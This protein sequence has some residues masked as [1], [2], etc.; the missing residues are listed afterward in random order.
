MTDFA[1]S[2]RNL[3]TDFLAVVVQ[4]LSQ[5]ELEF[6]LKRVVHHAGRT[7]WQATQEGFLRQLDQP[8]EAAESA[9]RSFKRARLASETDTHEMRM[10][11]EKEVSKSQYFLAAHNLFWPMVVMPWVVR[12][13]H[14]QLKD[15]PVSSAMHRGLGHIKFSAFQTLDDGTVV[16]VRLVTDTWPDVV[17]SALCYDC[18]PLHWRRANEDAAKQ[19]VRECAQDFADA[20]RVLADVVSETVSEA[21]NDPEAHDMGTAKIQPHQELALSKRKSHI[22]QALFYGKVF[23]PDDRWSTARIAEKA[24]GIS[25]DPE[26]FKVPISELRK[27]DL[28]NTKAGR[29]GGCWLTPEGA[30]AA[31]QLLTP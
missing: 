2:F 20:C 1:A 27:D 4:H 3:A 31:Q 17:V 29:D 5:D 12:H 28:I 10:I 23:R 19:E 25:A 24:E 13:H 21:R 14:D 11:A 16:E 15:S 22:L 6:N 9:W 18:D 7:A 8:V 26:G 30:E